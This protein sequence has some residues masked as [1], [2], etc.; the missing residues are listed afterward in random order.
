MVTS[1]PI[2]LKGT[3]KLSDDPDP[4]NYIADD[5]VTKS[6]LYKTSIST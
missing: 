5:P 2:S 4:P 6:I 3:V 1:P